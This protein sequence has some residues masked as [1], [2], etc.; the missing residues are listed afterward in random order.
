M[1]KPQ[2]KYPRWYRIIRYYV[3]CLWY[4]VLFPLGAKEDDFSKQ[5]KKKNKRL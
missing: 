4:Y 2:K 5:F 3:N 1:D